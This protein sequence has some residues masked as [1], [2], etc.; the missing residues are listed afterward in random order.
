LVKVGL[1]ILSLLFVGAL[2]ACGGDQPTAI[3][4]G[5]GAT[6]APATTAPSATNTPTTEPA[7]SDPPS[8][9][10]SSD[11]PA[12]TPPAATEAPRQRPEG[13]DAFD[14]A[15]SLGGPGGTFS[16]AEETRPVFMVFWAEW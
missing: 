3:D 7:V 1:R 2:A 15:L 12:T 13:P 4:L 5:G 16:L 9:E 6:V 14:F 8:T 10:P 11:A